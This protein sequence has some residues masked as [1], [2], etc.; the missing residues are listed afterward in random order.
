[1]NKGHEYNMYLVMFPFTQGVSRKT[2]NYKAK[3][4]FMN[5]LLLLLFVILVTGCTSNG[6]KPLSTFVYN[7]SDEVSIL[8]LLKGKGTPIKV[9]EPMPVI[10][11]SDIIEDYRYIP[12]ETTSQS[13][14]G[15]IRKVE[16]YKDRIY[17]YDVETNMVYIY[18]KSGK[19]LRKIGQKGGG[20]GEFTTLLYGFMIDPMQIVC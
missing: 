6:N 10:N 7:E 8:S 5:K 17:I 3:I 1:M 15:M 20:P 13:L 14:M 19:F 2:G 12:L 16:F 4:E 9:E 11:T 18:D